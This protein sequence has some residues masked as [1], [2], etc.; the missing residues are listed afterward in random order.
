MYTYEYICEGEIGGGRG[1]KREEEGGR[2]RKR[3]DEGGRERMREEERG[4][5]ITREEE[6]GIASTR[7]CVLEC[8]CESVY[9]EIH[10]YIQTCIYM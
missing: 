7:M 6:R 2:G 5:D 1:R 3:E 8:V 9:I 4:R 10:M